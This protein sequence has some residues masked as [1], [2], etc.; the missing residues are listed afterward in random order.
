MIVTKTPLRISFFGGGTDLPEFYEQYT[1]KV[2]STTINVFMHIVINESVN[3][4]VKVCYDSIEITDT[5]SQVKHDRVRETLL[6]YNVNNNIEI[7]SF[8][9]IPTKGTG[10]GSSSSFTVGLCSAL[11]SRNG[12]R[13]SPSSIAEKAYKIERVRCND[14]LGKQDQ[15]AAS[16]GG[17]NLFTFKKDTTVIQ[18]VKVEQFTINQ[19]E[20]NLLF[21]YTGTRRNA[22]DILQDQAKSTRDGI[23]V[24]FLQELARCADI[25]LNYLEQGQV[26]K[27]GLLLNHAWDIKK[28]ISSGI[29]NS[30][31]DFYY[32]EAIKAGALGGKL[33]GAGGGGY[34]MFY[35]ESEKHDQI[36]KSIP[37]QEYKFNFS[38]TG[39]EVVYEH[40]T[41]Y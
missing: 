33:L 6:E 24:N 9:H 39:T 25:G 28:Q 18:P 12:Q 5:A 38:N 1:G 34:L 36:R 17:L 27:F 14:S 4:R 7:S 8:C 20:K 37:L 11:E 15:Y 32:E 16:V 35:A 26:N 13:S 2:L 21:F 31:I 19:L 40:I 41:S 23:N 22:N 3:K 29:S 10:L 30:E